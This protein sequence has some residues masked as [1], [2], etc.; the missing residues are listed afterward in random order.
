MKKT[1]WLIAIPA[2]VIAAVVSC[3]GGGGGS[4]NA[5]DPPTKALFTDPTGTLTADNVTAATQSAVEANKAGS[6]VGGLLQSFG[7]GSRLAMLASKTLKKTF[8]QYAA[9]DFSAVEACLTDMNVNQETGELTSATMNLKC[10]SDANAFEGSGCT[11]AGSIGFSGTGTGDAAVVNVTL[12]GTSLTCAG[13]DFTTVT[14]NGE[15]NLAGSLTSA[16]ETLGGAGVSCWNVSCTVDTETAAV[17]ECFYNGDFLVDDGSGMSMVCQGLESD[18][19]TLTATWLD[20]VGAKTV[21]CTVPAD[22]RT[23]SCSDSKGVVKV[24]SCTI[25]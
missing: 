19:T 25:N 11:A 6:A 10:L 13:G 12:S 15:V 21:T 22:G 20:S 5:A 17:N 3:G 24:A 18:C 16:P 2:L 23:E 1:I 8:P 9:V 14:C 7:S 4:K